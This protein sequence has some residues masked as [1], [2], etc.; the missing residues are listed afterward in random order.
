MLNRLLGNEKRKAKGLIKMFSNRRRCHKLTKFPTVDSRVNNKTQFPVGKHSQAHKG[1]VKKF[2]FKSH[3]WLVNV[4]TD[5]ADVCPDLSK[6]KRG[7]ACI[8]H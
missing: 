5:Q 8:E 3:T 6:I 7:F 4:C 1:N 2:R